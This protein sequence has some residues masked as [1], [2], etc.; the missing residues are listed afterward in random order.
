MSSR[1]VTNFSKYS[2]Y[3]IIP[4]PSDSVTT[5]LSTLCSSTVD[6]LL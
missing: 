3:P 6:K 5:C 4:F 2:A 1:E